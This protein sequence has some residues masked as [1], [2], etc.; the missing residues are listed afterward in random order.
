VLRGDGGE[1]ARLA[2]SRLRRLP[3]R[4]PTRRADL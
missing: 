2:R 4:A 1:R 3:V